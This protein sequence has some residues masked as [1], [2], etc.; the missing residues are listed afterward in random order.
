[1]LIA[2]KEHSLAK[3]MV[4]TTAGRKQAGLFENE[5]KLPGSLT[6]WA[7]NRHPLRLA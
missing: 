6:V 3:L 4:A 2:G 5:E 7:Q 1:M